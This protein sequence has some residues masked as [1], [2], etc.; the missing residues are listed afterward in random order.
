MKSRKQVLEE[1][2]IKKE[3]V[4][5]TVFPTPDICAVNDSFELN[6]REIKIGA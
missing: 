1:V 4:E 3:I 2:K 6:T 5:K